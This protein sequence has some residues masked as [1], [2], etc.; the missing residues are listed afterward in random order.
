MNVLGGGQEENKQTFTKISRVAEQTVK[1]VNK[2]ET[3]NILL[4]C[5]FD[6]LVPFKIILL[7]Q[8]YFR[9][10]FII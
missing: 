6:K 7:F 1:N 10:C 2:K 4:L 3:K 8:L 5:I 9:F